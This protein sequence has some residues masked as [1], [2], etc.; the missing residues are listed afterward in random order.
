ATLTTALI[1]SVPSGVVIAATPSI[2]TTCGGVG[3]PVA[4]A[5]GSTV[6]LPAG[7]AIPANGSC[8]VTVEVTAAVGGS[9]INTLS[10]GALVTTNGSNA[11]PAVA[12]LTVVA[13]L[14]P[15]TLGKA[16]SPATISAGD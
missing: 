14:A 16:F 15:P 5:G 9:Y 7:R 4:V 13:L 1:D 12:T 6:S 11:G 8:T 10:A 2:S 3:A